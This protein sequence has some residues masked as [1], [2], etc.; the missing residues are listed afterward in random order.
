VP[1]T[2]FINGIRFFSIGS[3][4]Y[5]FGTNYTYGINDVLIS[6]AFLVGFSVIMCLFALRTFKK[7]N[8]V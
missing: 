8:V 1:L 5:A 6:L 4:F 3:D 2:Y 7:V